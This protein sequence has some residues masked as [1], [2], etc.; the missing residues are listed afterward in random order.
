MLHFMGLPNSTI[1][2]SSLERLFL[3]YRWNWKK[4]MFVLGPGEM[5]D[6]NID[7]KVSSKIDDQQD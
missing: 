7:Q 6:S 1:G 2:V 3:G 4:E 5:L